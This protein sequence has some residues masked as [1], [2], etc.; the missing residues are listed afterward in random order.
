MLNAATDSGLSVPNDVE[1]VSMIGTKYSHIIRPSISNFYI[2]MIEVGKT[3]MYMLMDLIN[4]RLEEKN[5]KFNAK[6]IKN[7]SSLF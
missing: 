5:F 6:Y 4:D 1:V 2:D 3:S 7:E